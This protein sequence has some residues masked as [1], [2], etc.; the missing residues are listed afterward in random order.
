MPSGLTMFGP[1][2]PLGFAARCKEGRAL[3]KCVPSVDPFSFYIGAIVDG[4]DYVVTE[5]TTTPG[6]YP[7]TMAANG[8]VDV[9]AGGDM[10]R[11]LLHAELYSRRL[12]MWTGDSIQ[13]IN[14]HLPVGTLTT[15]EL[16]V[17]VAMDALNLVALFTDV[18]HDPLDLLPI[19]GTLPPGTSITGGVLTGVPSAV[20]SGFFQVVARDPPGDFGTA[21]VNWTITAAPVTI[22]AG[23]LTEEVRVKTH[24]NGALTN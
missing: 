20:G 8:I 18:D 19:L 22:T 3:V 2:P 10:T 4:G 24:V 16:V 7:A 11:Q 12:Q 21:Q 14:N 15:L 6:G 1:G 9:R 17:G 5:R 13:Y 23:G